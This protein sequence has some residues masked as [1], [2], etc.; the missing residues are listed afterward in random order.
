[1]WTS[2]LETRTIALSI[3]PKLLYIDLY[4]ILITHPHWKTYLNSD[5][6]I[7]QTYKSLLWN[8]TETAVRI[9]V[10]INIFILAFFKN[11][12]VITLFV[13]PHANIYWVLISTGA[14][15]LV[16]LSSQENSVWKVPLY[17]YFTEWENEAYKHQM[18]SFPYGST[19]RKERGQEPWSFIL[20]A[21]LLNQC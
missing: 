13:K 11:H 19:S 2:Y 4:S 20:R 8:A 16:T 17:S 6:K 5:F 7:L 18:Q 15:H 12:S 3:N 14:E 9:H 21:H 1:M 10:S